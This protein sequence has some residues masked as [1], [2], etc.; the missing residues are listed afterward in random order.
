MSKATEHFFDEKKEW[1]IA[2]DEL[3][4]CYLRPYMNKLFKTNKTNVYIDCFSGAGK[5]GDQP[6]EYVNIEDDSVPESFGSPLIALK[7]IYR[8]LGDTK[9]PIPRYLAIFIEKKYSQDLIANLEESQFSSAR[10]RVLDGEYQ[11]LIQNIMDK[12]IEHYKRPNLLCYLDPYGVKVLKMDYLKRFMRDELSSIE[13]LINFNSFG[14]FRYACGAKNITIR[15]QELKKPDEVDEMTPLTKNEGANRLEIFDEILGTRAWNR[16]I[17]SYQSNLIDGYKA[18]R[19]ISGLYRK[20]LKRK[21]RFEYVLNIPIRLNDSVHPKYRMIYA[22]NHDH[23]AYLMGNVMHNRQHYLY[24]QNAISKSG[25]LSLFDP[26]DLNQERPMDE[27]VL[28]LLDMEGELGG[29]RFYA[30]FY[31]RYYL[32]SR[33]GEA[34]KKLEKDGMISIERVPAT[35]ATG[36][37]SKFLT[38]KQGQK[39]FIKLNK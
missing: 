7:E 1:S 30:K 21:L 25:S 3:L 15:E 36:R 29:I 37:P 20:Q 5:F 4:R 23:G 38:E 26:E 10:Y 18:E 22:T 13:L 27:C 39:L 8:S 35:T 14:F 19:L 6:I 12:I 16:V 33:L 32:T 28:E 11:H 31:D 17:A 2:K 9:A 24:D 34:L